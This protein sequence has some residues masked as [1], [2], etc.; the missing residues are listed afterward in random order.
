MYMQ[1]A[2]VCWCAQRHHAGASCL[3]QTMISCTVCDQSHGIQAQD[4]SGDSSSD[5][6]PRL[7]VPH[8]ALPAPRAVQSNAKGKLQW[9]DTLPTARRPPSAG[10]GLSLK[11]QA[12]SPRWGARHSIGP[13]LVSPALQ[14]RT[15]VGYAVPL[16]RRFVPSRSS[17]SS[18]RA[19]SEDESDTEHVGRGEGLHRA[20]SVSAPK[21]QQSHD[22]SKSLIELSELGSGGIATAGQ[23]FLG[24]PFPQLSSA[25]SLP[26]WQLDPAQQQPTQGQSQFGG[27]LGNLSNAA[28]S[29]DSDNPKQRLLP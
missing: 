17:F 1:A 24:S 2:S 5:E 11:Q 10:P 4:L 26:P 23:A 15:S 29:E 14:A 19:L 16:Q 25:E 28:A 6:G 3:P 7:Q 27:E 8:Q 13:A 21:R 18:R 9:I 20:Q 22:M 12:S